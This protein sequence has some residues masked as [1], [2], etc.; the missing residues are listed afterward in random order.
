M[1]AHPAGGA[2]GTGGSRAGRPTWCP[3]VSA[4]AR[5]RRV[6]PCL[7]PPWQPTPRSLTGRGGN[8]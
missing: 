7:R 6:R 3:P 1:I 5:A 8:V 2:V 4:S